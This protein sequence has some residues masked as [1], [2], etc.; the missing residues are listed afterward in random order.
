M[1]MIK[2]IKSLPMAVA[3]AAILAAVPMP[4]GTPLFGEQAAFAQAEQQKS[5]AKTRKVPAMTL[6]AHK[7]IQKAQEAMDLK[8]YG[9]AKEILAD[10]LERKRL[11]DYE[12]AVAWQLR[13][14]IA[15][16]EDDTN[17]TIRAYERILSYADSIPEALELSIIYGLAQLYYTEERFDDALR[18]VNM[19]EDRVDPTLVSVSH[20]S[21]ISNLH[22]VRNDFPKALEYIY[23]AI[24]TAKSLDTVEVKE[25]WYGLA[26]SAHWELGQF[27]KVRDVLEILLI[28]WPKPRYW[29]QLA[30]IYQEL[31]QEQTSYSLTE[32]AYK[33]GFLDDNE[34]QLVNVAQIQLARSA[35]I[36]CAWILEKAFKE[37]RVERTAQNE[38]T[39]GQCYMMAYEYEK[40]LAPLAK[41][42]SGDKDGD[43]WFQIGQ[44]QMQLGHYKDAIE[45]FDS[46]KTAFKNDKSDKAK[47]RILSATMQSGQALTELKRFKEARD[48]FKS[49]KRLATDRKDK[50]MV[51]QWED[52]LRAE[53]ER[54]KMLKG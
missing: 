23:R 6:D 24:D 15:Y 25:G 16:E 49:A 36:K 28:N 42:A 14:M 10:L 31:G 3:A 45:S 21:F 40:A 7:Q 2:T 33:Q 43:L 47:E 11:N 38:K 19:W 9:E 20:L 39:L 13:A 29:T 34:Q 27:E 26:L 37:D 35:P 51:G 4:E 30:G 8:A 46:V 1:S 18:Y 12:R 44:V 17:E 50:R 41:A 22:Y 53:E 5:Q 54:E 48:A 52:Y 32:A